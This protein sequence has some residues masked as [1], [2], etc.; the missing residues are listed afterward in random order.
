MP[1]SPEGRSRAKRR[2]R[3][4]ITADRIGEHLY[5]PTIT[6]LLSGAE[7]DLLSD[8]RSLLLELAEAKPR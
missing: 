1:D 3:C 2:H 8:A 5:D 7:L 4:E 6:D